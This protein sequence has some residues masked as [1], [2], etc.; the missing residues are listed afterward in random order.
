MKSICLKCQGTGIEGYVDHGSAQY[1]Q[2]AVEAI[3]CSVC[4]GFGNHQHK[5]YILWYAWDTWQ[6]HSIYFNRR[7]A[8]EKKEKLMK[9]EP[10]YRYMGYQIEEKIVL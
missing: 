3:C 9:A 4:D 6:I 5:V 2:S 8:E 7:D 1:G 10:P